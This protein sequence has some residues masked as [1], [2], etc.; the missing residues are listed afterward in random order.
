MNSYGVGVLLPAKFRDGVDGDQRKE[1]LDQE[2]FEK[3]IEAHGVEQLV[4]VG[5]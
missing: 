4:G 3:A 1:S 5:S 2:R